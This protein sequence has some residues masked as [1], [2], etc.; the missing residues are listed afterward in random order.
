MACPIFKVVR[1]A[2]FLSLA[3]S[4][5]ADNTLTAEASIVKGIYCSLPNSD[6]DLLVNFTVTYRNGLGSPVI[7]ATPNLV[8]GYRLFRDEEDVALNRPVRKFV[9]ASTAMFEA[10]KIDRLKPDPA[11]FETVQ[12]EGVAHRIYNVQLLVGGPGVHSLESDDYYLLVSIDTWPANRRSGES[13]ARSWERWGKLWLNPIQLPPMR[14]HVEKAPEI[15]P[16][17][18]R[19]D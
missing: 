16:C 6:I 15:R 11:L 5:P 19:V 10:S 18:L 2:F 9:S 13:L 7:L 4:L 17:P 12:P 1:I 3:P 14:L 8:K